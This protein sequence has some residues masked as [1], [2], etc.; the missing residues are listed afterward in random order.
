MD[1]RCDQLADCLM[2]WQWPD[3][4]W[5]CDRKPDAATSSFWESLIPLRGLSAYAQATGDAK[6]TAAAERAAEL[7]ERIRDRLGISVHRRSVER[8]LARGKKNN[9][10]HGG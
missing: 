1:D 4:G 5:N 7:A 8:A 6:A 3:G 9:D 10:P 2:R